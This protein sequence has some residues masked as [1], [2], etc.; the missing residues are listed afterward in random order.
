MR[1]KTNEQF[2][3]DVREVH[4][5]K[6]DLSRVVYAGRNRKV[7]VGCRD[8]G[9][10]LKNAGDLL[11]GSG[12]PY[13]YHGYSI[14]DNQD[15]KTETF[16]RNA[17]RTHGDSYDYTKVEYVLSNEKVRIIC[18]EHGEFHQT[19]NHHLRGGR[20]TKCPSPHNQGTVIFRS[21]GQKFFE[22]LERLCET[23]CA[24][25]TLKI[26]YQGDYYHK[27]GVTEQGS[28]WDRTRHIKR[29]L[30]GCEVWDTMFEVLTY[31]KAYFLE[32]RL[33]AFLSSRRENIE[34]SFKGKTETFTFDEHLQEYAE[35]LLD[36]VASMSSEDVL[37]RWRDTLV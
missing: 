18:P 35:L 19:P 16:I 14:Y 1:M 26:N 2:L 30:G 21:W 28:T 11:N 7:E 6:F 36:E 10:F 34:A 33:I 22:G 23:P 8:H 24:T 12:C 32:D 4:K 27:V 31:P 20:C 29:K 37:T 13:C 25:Y 9:F 5:D 3:K 15:T 17:R